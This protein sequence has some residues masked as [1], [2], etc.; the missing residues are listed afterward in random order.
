MSMVSFE[1][2]IQQVNTERNGA[3]ALAVTEIDANKQVG[4]L[5]DIKTSREVLGRWRSTGLAP[6]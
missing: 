1:W 3:D 4:A 6:A 5:E 2:K